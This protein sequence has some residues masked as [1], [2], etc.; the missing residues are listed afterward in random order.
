MLSATFGNGFAV[1]GI[2]IALHDV[3]GKSLG[4]PVHALYGGARRELLPVYAS[5]PGYYVDQG[6]ET[7]WSREVLELCDR[8]FRAVKLRIGRYPVERELPV[9]GEVRQAIGSAMRLMA[10]ANAA[11]SPAI[12]L[13]VADA[14]AEL[15]FDWLEEPLPQAGYH[16]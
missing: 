9:L 7:H 12:A 1:G 6:P 8:G 3:W 14:L 4:V 5:L 2:D 10:D 13:R 11:H 16:G 15:D